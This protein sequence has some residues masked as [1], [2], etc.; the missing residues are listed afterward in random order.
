MFGWLKRLFGIG[1]A[2]V[3]SLLDKME[4]PVKMTEQGIKDLKTDLDKSLQA[5]AEVKSMYIKSRK[6]LDQ[7]RKKSSDYELKAVQLLQKAQSGGLDEAEADRLAQ[8]ALDE[9]NRV[10]QRIAQHEK[11]TAQYEK[12]QHE[13]EGKVG[14]LKSAITKYENELR[15]LKARS[16]VS[17]A[18]KRV[19][20]IS[21]GVDASGT[22]ARL[23]RMKEKVDQQEALA[24][25]YGE[26]A[27]ENKSVDDEIDSALGSTG[28]SE[29]LN[30][31]KAKMNSQQQIESGDSSASPS[32]NTSG[33]LS[34]LEKLKQKL[35]E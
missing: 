10:D 7:D 3:N 11:D 4:D 6:Q 30:Q 26:M 12:L 18:A 25:A 14:Q 34:E 5:L 23:E 16:Q 20:E 2:E 8:K 21:S 15:T 17:K 13:M 19:N 32:A 24:Q 29:A 22:I 28:G 31:L 1:K 27:D 35:K 33:E 9:K